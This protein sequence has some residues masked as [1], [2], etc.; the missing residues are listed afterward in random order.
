[1]S[2]EIPGMFFAYSSQP[3]FVGEAIE[4]F[5][6][7]FN[8]SKQ[9][10]IFTWKNMDISGMSIT[11]EI[12][13]SIDEREIFGCD[14][15]TLN[16][17][18]LFELGYAIAK[19]KKIWI[20]LNQ[21]YDGA[22]G[23]YSS[24]RVL[25]NI[26]YFGYSN[27]GELL[28][29]F[30]EMRIFREDR[31]SLSAQKELFAV[32]DY[33]DIFALK[34]QSRLDII[35]AP[36]EALRGY[37]LKVTVDDPGES[38]FYSLE[39]YCRHIYSAY[40]V[41]LQFMGDNI[42]NRDMHNCKAALLAGIS[43]GLEK[44]TL[45][46]AQ[47]PFKIPSDLP[48]MINLVSGVKQAKKITTDWTE[49]LISVKDERDRARVDY[50]NQSARLAK[51]GLIRIG[52][53]VAENEAEKLPLYFIETAAYREVISGSQSIFVGRKGSG[54]SA[55]LLAAQQHFSTEKTNLVIQFNPVGY[56]IESVITLLSS[57]KD[58]HRRGFFADALWKYLIYSELAE[59]ISRKF[60]IFPDSTPDLN[61]TALLEFLEKNQYI[62]SDSFSERLAVVMKMIDS[63]ISKN[64]HKD[65]RENISNILY[66]Q[67]VTKLKSLTNPILVNYKQIIILVD[68][69]DKGWT[70][71]SDTKSL[72]E[73]LFSLISLAKHLPD[74]ISK[75]IRGKARVSVKMTVFLRSDIY[76]IMQEYARE[77]DKLVVQKIEWNNK[78]MLVRVMDKRVMHS[79]GL[80]SPTDAWREI[81]DTRDNGEDVKNFIL[82]HTRPRP[83]DIIS[84]MTNVIGSAVNS[85]HPK[86]TDSDLQSGLR[87]YS[88]WVF[89]SLLEEDDPSRDKLERIIDTFFAEKEVYEEGE[90]LANIKIVCDAQPDIDYYFDLL[91]DTNFLEIETKPGEFVTV[92]DAL[93]RERALKIAR[94]RAT[95]NGSEVKFRVSKPFRISLGIEDI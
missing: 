35:N 20:T 2:A 90:I 15:T 21:E 34:A 64:P 73:I 54:K 82:D 22:L 49:N 50:E 1:M 70:A 72:S 5:A 69:L 29:E 77:R 37:N 31:V 87:E 16:L 7:E 63:E 48:E 62:T 58:S 42:A 9:C 71:D 24:F 80:K 19:G 46:T 27:Q 88:Y 40:G 4:S 36:I 39:W 84:M 25:S 60:R 86:V 78:E 75:E 76:S 91:C 74:E 67:L 83:R 41:F 89:D 44:Y 93:E 6:A 8:K 12:L 3:S 81:F 55:N 14:L 17:N 43:I 32:K 95:K 56:E 52:E 85:G 53:I 28:K 10:E 47:D 23:K 61:E 59:N 68:N 26:G 11:K 45:F 66:S 92:S 18:V 65:L 79:S 38:S 13:S 30:Y 57:I 33:I 94:V 51:L